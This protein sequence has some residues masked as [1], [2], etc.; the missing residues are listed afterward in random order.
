MQL[1]YEGPWAAGSCPWRGWSVWAPAAGVP[2]TSQRMV[3][4]SAMGPHT[5]RVAP[6]WIPGWHL[7]EEHNPGHFTESSPARDGTGRPPITGAQ[8]SVTP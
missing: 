3:G 6:I 5:C 8:I 2:T 4:P 1:G 7:Q